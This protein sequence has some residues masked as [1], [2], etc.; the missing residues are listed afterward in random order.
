MCRLAWPQ[1]AEADGSTRTLTSKVNLVDLAGSERADLTAD[2]K[3]LQ[4]GA[5]INKSLSALGN[6]INALTEG[7]GAG[8]ATGA[9]PG[10]KG[11]ST[12]RTS[13]K[14]GST[15]GG[16]GAGYV[17]Y[18]SSKLTRLLEES[19]G[20][21]TVTVMLATVSSEE[22]NVRET[23]A[24]LKYAQSRHAD[25]HRLRATSPARVASHQPD[26]PCVQVRA[27]RQEDHQHEEQERGQGGQAT[28]P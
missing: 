10:S 20:G 24:T 23:L 13:S 25:D 19:L 3:Q 8:G 26:P 2:A 16:G 4:E 7:G 9:T 18:R 14:G 17:P 15:A 11:K 21:N 5:A 28:H 1:I 12:A 6:V 27:A 22:R